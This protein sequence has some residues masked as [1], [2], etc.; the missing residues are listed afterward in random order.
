M[1]TQPEVLNDSMSSSAGWRCGACGGLIRR[2]EDGRVEWLALE[3]G[4]G[5]TRISGLQLV[6]NLATSPISSGCQYDAREEFQRN[7]SIV[8]GLSL[9]HFVG[10][11]GLMFLL[12]L[13]LMT[14]GEKVAE[15][16]I[17]LVKRVQIPGYEQARELF[18]PAIEQGLFSP[19]IGNGFYLQSEI[20]SV[21]RWI[22]GIT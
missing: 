18:Q 1:S 20:H 21:L 12:S 17:E 7:R 10:P 13:M 9:D 5:K 19:A 3:E 22:P 14:S 11:D 4:S 16:V 6:H 2:V 15:D 8:E